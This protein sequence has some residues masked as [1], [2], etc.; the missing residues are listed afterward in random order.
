MEL[1]GDSA[2]DW[3]RPFSATL[4]LV[5]KAPVAALNAAR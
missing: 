1:S 2:N 4:K 3:T 5:I